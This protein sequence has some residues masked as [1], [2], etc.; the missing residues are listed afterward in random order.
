MKPP[1]VLVSGVVLGIAIGVLVRPAG[2]TG[3][4][5]G[6]EAGGS[7]AEGRRVSPRTMA[8]AGGQRPDSGAEQ[9]LSAM[10][11]G[12]S[13]SELTTDEAYRIIEPLLATERYADPLE[14]A[15]AYYQIQLLTSRLPPKVLEELMEK[16]AVN[17]VSEIRL[18]QI[19]SSYARRDW[20]KALAWASAQP[21]ADRLRSRAISLLADAEPER[22]AALYEKELL[23][24]RGQTG[25]LEAA[26]NISASTAKQGPEA[27]FKFLGSVP[28]SAFFMMIHQGARNT[29]KDQVPA[30]IEQLN[31]RAEA[32]TLDKSLVAGVMGQIARKHPEEARKWLDT[33]EAGPKRS[34]QEFSLATNLARDGK[35]EEAEALMKSAMAGVPGKEKEFALQ[36]LPALVQLSPQLAEKLLAQLPEGEKLTP[37]D[38]AGWRVSTSSRPDRMVDVAKLFTTPDE[39]A[40]YLVDS[41][42]GLQNDLNAQ[43][44]KI[45]AHRVES[46]GLTGEAAARVTEALEAQRVKVLGK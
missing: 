1:L 9:M 40:T 20:E 10:L 21:D 14:H 23:E 31:Q 16:G 6:A 2:L 34:S 29:P 5:A 26:M 22:A 13:V 3:G 18:D 12:R 28:S 24:G 42:K 35:Q 36:N 30:F 32:G 11:K 38:A 19:F 41:F 33:L 25:S 45:I 37:A 44:L 43:D 15:K 17:G 39:Q 8:A 7:A 4:S 46:L 27:F